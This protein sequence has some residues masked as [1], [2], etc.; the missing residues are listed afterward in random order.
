MNV[1]EALIREIVTKVLE[2]SAGKGGKPVWV[3]V[4]LP[5][6][7]PTWAPLGV[8]VSVKVDVVAGP[9]IEMV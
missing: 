4:K 2:E 8:V 7:S 9:P 3:T 1:S 6:L 5:H